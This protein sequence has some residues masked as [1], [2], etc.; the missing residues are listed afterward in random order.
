MRPLPRLAALPLPALWLSAA[1]AQPAD[2]LNGKWFV[3]FPLPVGERSSE[4]VL[5]SDG[6]VWRDFPIGK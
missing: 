4:L 2:S 6:G 3:K 1:L 5:N